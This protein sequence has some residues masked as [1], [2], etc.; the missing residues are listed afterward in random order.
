MSYEIDNNHDVELCKCQH[1]LDKYEGLLLEAV[2]TME[3]AANNAHNEEV[4]KILT[5]GYNK[6]K[7]GI[8]E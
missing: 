6:I 8:N 2:K 3:D 4:F 5:V 1:Y 7:D